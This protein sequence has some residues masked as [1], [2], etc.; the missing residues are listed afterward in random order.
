[1]GVDQ[2]DASEDAPRPGEPD[3]ADVLSLILPSV[4]DGLAGV[5]VGVG[6]ATTYSAHT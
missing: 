1:M 4:L 3:A 2:V 6:H 5:G